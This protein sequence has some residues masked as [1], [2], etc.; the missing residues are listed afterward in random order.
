MSEKI[1]NA[2]IKDIHEFMDPQWGIGTSD[3]QFNIQ[4][5]WYHNLFEYYSVQP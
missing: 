2:S 4:S 5:N 3:I 1:I